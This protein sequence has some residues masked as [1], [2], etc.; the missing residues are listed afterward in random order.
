MQTAA[1]KVWLPGSKTAEAVKVK[2]G[3]PNSHR[4]LCSCRRKKHKERLVEVDRR[5]K[6]VRRLVLI[7]AVDQTWKVNQDAAWEAGR[8]CQTDVLCRNTA[9]GCP[10]GDNQPKVDWVW[11]YPTVNVEA[12]DSAVLDSEHN[13]RIEPSRYP[14][15]ATVVLSIYALRLVHAA[16]RT[17]KCS[18]LHVEY[19]TRSL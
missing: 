19:A 12:V 6:Q 1:V 14:V 5:E 9:R 13:L 2:F 17:L 15:Q 16:S 7:V 11:T 8:Q 3:S 18:S 10:V 4:L